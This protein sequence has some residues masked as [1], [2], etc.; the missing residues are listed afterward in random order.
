MGDVLKRGDYPCIEAQLDEHGD[1][2]RLPEKVFDADSRTSTRGA[3]G[4][5]RRNMTR[6]PV[7]RPAL[8]FPAGASARRSFASAPCCGP[9][10]SEAAARHPHRARVRR[11]C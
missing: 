11:P 6:G 5:V 4:T 2:E 10:N 3:N 1:E 7:S 9:S 8:L